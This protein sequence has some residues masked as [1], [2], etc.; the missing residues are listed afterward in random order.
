[1]K[2]WKSNIYG[3]LAEFFGVNPASLT[4]LSLTHVLQSSDILSFNYSFDTTCLLW[5]ESFYPIFLFS[6]F[7][8]VR[9]LYHFVLYKEKCQKRQM[10]FL[11]SRYFIENIRKTHRRLIDWHRCLYLLF[12]NREISFFVNAK[13]IW[14]VQ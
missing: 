1:L 8:Y 6:Q 2:L 10:L 14:N 4:L 12:K 11:L 3:S 13:I 9:V 7:L 5:D